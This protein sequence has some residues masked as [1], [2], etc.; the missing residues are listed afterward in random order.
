M[1]AG[2][3]ATMGG[4]PAMGGIVRSGG[5]LAVGGET[6]LGGLPEMGGEMASG[7]IA[8]MGGMITTGGE[9][10]SGG[11]PQMG[12]M[13]SGGEGSGGILAMGGIMTSGGRMDTGGMTGTGGNA[14][15]D[16]G[17]SCHASGTLMVVN[18]AMTSYMVDQVANPT[19]TF[20]RGSTYVF[21]VNATG[22]PFYIKTVRSNGT[23]NAYSMGVTGNG[24]DA[25]D[26]TFV[27]PAA[28]PDTLFYDCAIHAAMGGTIHI[29]N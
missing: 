20:C 27:V 25:G 8:Q 17:A 18:N 6:G 5:F 13:A 16:A 15:A 22:H 26:V 14:H 1:G 19:L 29:V 12:G 9:I 21:S 28:A 4:V 3:M 2:G 23:G 24:S 11:I 10:A 7:G